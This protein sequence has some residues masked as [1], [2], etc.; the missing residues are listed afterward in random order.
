MAGTTPDTATTTDDPNTPCCNN[1]PWT[2][3]AACAWT[4]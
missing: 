2:N 4:A 3:C 1:T